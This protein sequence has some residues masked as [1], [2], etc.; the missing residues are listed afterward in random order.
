MLKKSLLAAV[1][2]AG[3][4]LATLQSVA[5]ELP[6][7]PFIHARGTGFMFVQPDLGEIDFEIT[8]HNAAPEAAQE[9]VQQRVAEIKA[10]AAEKGVAAADVE[11]TDIRREIRKNNAVEPEYAIKCTVHIVVRDLGKWRELMAPLLRMPNVDGFGTVF[12]VTER[13]KIETELMG[14]AVREATL[15]ADAMAVGFGKRVG[16]VTGVSS[17]ELK[18]I[19]RSIG[20]APSDR[21][22]SSSSTKNTP[23]DEA[24]LMMVT[25]LKMSQS[26]D[27]IFRIK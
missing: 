26:V 17:D 13:V 20:L 7:Y 16:A 24:E 22:R 5:A 1:L 12:G 4:A 3:L 11:F 10:L 18:N 14:K 2:T 9:L 21:P 25:A 27:V 23:Q 8:S 15:K 19:T 6:S